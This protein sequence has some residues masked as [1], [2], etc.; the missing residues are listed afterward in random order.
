MGEIR[1]FGCQA[2]GSGSPQGYAQAVFGVSVLSGSRKVVRVRSCIAVLAACIVAM[3]TLLSGAIHNDIF[4]SLPDDA[5]VICIGSHNAGDSDQ[6]SSG[7]PTADKTYCML[8]TLARIAPAILPAHHVIARIDART[9][10]AFPASNDDQVTDF[11]SP[12]GRY[13]RGP[14]DRALFVG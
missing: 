3:Q 11:H 2:R 14:P 10:L 4:D 13:Q 7:K 1:R 5:F 12:T 6:D 9:T 8:C